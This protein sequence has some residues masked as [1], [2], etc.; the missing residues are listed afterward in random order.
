MQEPHCKTL[1]FRGLQSVYHFSFHAEVVYQV[2]QLY[3]LTLY[4]ALV[5]LRPSSQCHGSARYVSN[6]TIQLA[7][8][9]V[10]SRELA[11]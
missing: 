8:S 5:S 2:Y 9:L 1:L 6:M 10:C 4:H 3:A 11:V 7:T